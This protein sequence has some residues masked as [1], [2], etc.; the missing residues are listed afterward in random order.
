ML[1]GNITE[2]CMV[3]FV[4]FFVLRTVVNAILTLNLKK[5][6]VESQLRLTLEADEAESN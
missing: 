2:Y 5:F 4:G 3:Y 6:S 1:L